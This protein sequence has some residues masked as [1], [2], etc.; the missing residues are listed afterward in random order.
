MQ[1]DLLP[2]PVNGNLRNA[3]VIILMLNPGF[4]DSDAQWGTAFSRSV[5]LD[6]ERANLLQSDWPDKF[7]MFDLNPKLAGSGGAKYWAGPLGPMKGKLGH[8][9]HALAGPDDYLHEDIRKELSNRI[10]IVQRVAYRSKS[11]RD[12]HR[13]RSSQEAFELARSLVA[14]GEKLVVIP[15]GIQHWGYPNPVKTS[16][17]IVYKHGLRAAHIAPTSAGYRAVVERLNQRVA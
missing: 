17:L 12:L 1:L 3:D 16:N 11:F 2:I 14:E 8:L 10:A 5:L 6:S 13:L 15:Y 4:S 9:A 7:P